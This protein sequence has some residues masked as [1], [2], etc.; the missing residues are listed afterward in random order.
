MPEK[1]EIA[2]KGI[3]LKKIEYRNTSLM[4]TI[5]S[6]QLGMVSVL[7]KGIRKENNPEHANFDLGNEL[8]LM[9]IRS[10]S[11]LFYL[12]NSHLLNSFLHDISYEKSIY[13][14]AAIEIYLQFLIHENEAHEMYELLI[15]YWNYLT[16]IR[17]NEIL[18]FCRFLLRVFLFYGIPLNIT[19]CSLCH[20]PMNKISYMDTNN[21][22][23]LCSDCSLQNF[24]KEIY[25]IS[26]KV[27][28]ILLLLPQIGNVIHSLDLDYQEKKEILK[29]FMLHLEENFHKHFHIN[30]LHSL[31]KDTY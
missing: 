29:L 3:V 20:K 23:F 31:M 6:D 7:A 21:A 14:F 9:L 4:V 13:F 10:Q 19:E 16:T 28:K 5:L 24:N 8:D 1:K 12:K 2:T 27:S 15:F 25:R 30:S 18:I 17:T 22:G 26:P 11:E